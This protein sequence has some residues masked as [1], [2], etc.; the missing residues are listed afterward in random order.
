MFRQKHAE[1]QQ[2][3]WIATSEIVSTPANSFYQKLDGALA[4]LGFGEKV[5]SLCAPF[6]END[7]SKGG[8]PGIDPEVYFKMLMIGFFENLSSERGIAARCGDSLSIR[9]FL[10]YSLT[11]TTPDHSSLTVIRKRL[12]EEVFR[13]VFS[14]ILQALKKHK[15]LKGK[16]VAID[17]SVIEANA[18]LRSLQH[19][20]TGDDYWEYVK[21]LADAAGV[22][23]RDTAAVR[24]FDKKREDRTTSNKDWQNPHD[25]TAKVGRT[26]RGA[27]RMIYK[28]EHIVDLDTG[29]IL[30][31]DIRAGDEHDTDELAERLLDAEERI[32]TALGDDAD[33]ARIEIAVSDKGYYKVSELTAL[34]Q[35][36]IK[37]VISDPIDNRRIEKLPVEQQKAVRAAKRS[38]T[39]NYGKQLLK[40]RGMYVERSFEHVLDC[41]GARHTTLRGTENISKRYMIQTACMNLSLLMRKMIGIGTPKQALA[42]SNEAIIALLAT[43]GAFLTALLPHPMIVRLAATTPIISGDYSDYSSVFSCRH[44][45]AVLT[46]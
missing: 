24:R 39:A 22:D 37:T 8:R 3:I 26:K 7:P 19:R 18:S 2:N 12:S 20:L 38:V 9:G 34:Q 41:G 40:R 31:A 16:R 30:D 46:R 5:R 21:K 43:I 14:L 11:E 4:S 23:T 6:Y 33:I 15:L 35:H 42:A 44:S 10:H 25:L 36:G 13:A 29:A 17:A 1:Q 45:I 27:T 32:N 28:P